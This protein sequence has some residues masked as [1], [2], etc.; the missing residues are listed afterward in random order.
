MSGDSK[1]FVRK[2]LLGK[3]VLANP[4]TIPQPSN[5]TH[6][7]DTEFYAKRFIAKSFFVCGYRSVGHEDPT[8]KLVFPF[9]IGGKSTHAA[10][11]STSTWLDCIEQVQR[12]A[13]LQ[14][15]IPPR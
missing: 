14:Q 13:Q 7:G 6:S 4:L 9:D 8:C 12:P 3:I 5:Q 15:C 1:K 2:R 11:H 10:L